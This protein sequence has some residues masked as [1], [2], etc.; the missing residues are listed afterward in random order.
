MYREILSLAVDQGM[1]NER[2]PAGVG[3]GGSVFGAALT[4]AVIGA[5]AGFLIAM[6]TG[7]DASAPSAV[8]AI[9]GG[10]LLAILAP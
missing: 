5:A 10:A 7:R 6:L 9:V 2:E 1:F 4:G 8:G 3:L